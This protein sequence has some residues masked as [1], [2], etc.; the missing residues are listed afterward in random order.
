VD[1]TGPA[2][3]ISWLPGPAPQPDRPPTPPA[4]TAAPP[5]PGEQ[6]A[7][8]RPESQPAPRRRSP[9]GAAA[10]TEEITTLH[11]A[12]QRLRGD[13]DPVSAL[14]LLDEYDRKFPGGVLRPEAMVTR[15]EALLVLGRSEQAS[16]ALEALP[17]SLVERSP[18]LLVA[19]GELHAA[20]GRCEPALRDFSRAQAAG[21]DR[22]LERRVQL[23][24]AVCLPRDRQPQP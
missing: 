2:A 1:L 17:A 19:R 8:R 14:R 16:Q 22:E 6:A 7:P 23:G 5:A 18:R 4:A 12:L 15:V 24:R 21:I 13:V 3:R 11:A 10:T 9:R 20:R